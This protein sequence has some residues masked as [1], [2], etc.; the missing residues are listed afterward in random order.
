ME[1][2]NGGIKMLNI[3]NKF[4]IGQ[5]VYLL[6]KKNCKICNGNGH[7]FYGGYRL[8]CPRC[9]EEGDG[10]YK[11]MEG[12]HKITGIRTNTH[13]GENFSVRYNAGGNKRAE[14]RVF[15]TLEEAELACKELN[16]SL[17]TV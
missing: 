7:F 12:K 13:D 3:N 17:K 14:N 8:E 1:Y 11:V 2:R 16:D 5:E 6:Q 4:E 9:K 15:A 10:Q